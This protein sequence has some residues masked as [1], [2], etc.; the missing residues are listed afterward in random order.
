MA[1]GSYSMEWRGEMIVAKTKRAAIIGVNQTMA[2]CVEMAKTLV[3]VEFG[4]LQGSI[5]MEP[6]KPSG[7]GIKG[8][9]GSFDVNYAIWQE[10]GTS[11]MSA[12]PYL[13][14]SADFEYGLLES[15]IRAA[16]AGAA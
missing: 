2:K 16:A 1:K 9:W 4:T 11:V 13:R 6:A 7:A 3:R 12:Q 8:T 10:I 15:R 5:R 14:P